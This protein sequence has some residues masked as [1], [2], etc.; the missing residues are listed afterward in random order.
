MTPPEIQELVVTIASQI[1]IVGTGLLAAYFKLRS[2]VQ[3]KIQEV[4]THTDVTLQKLNGMLTYVIHSF[5]RPAWIKIASIRADGEIEFRML[6]LNDLYTESFDISRH[7][8]LGKTDLEAGWDKIEAD[9]MRTNDLHVW[10]SGQPTTFVE[11]VGGKPLRFRKIR[12]QSADG[13]LKGVMG[14]AVEC[15]E[16]QSCPFHKKPI[17]NQNFSV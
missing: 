9:K 4:K 10:S 14:Y 15:E 13:R 16:P 8:Y 2:E 7:E 6:E 12:V 11:V 1:L 3:A 5:D 17:D